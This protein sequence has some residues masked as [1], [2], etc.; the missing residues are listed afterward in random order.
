MRFGFFAQLKVRKIQ[1]IHGMKLV[2]GLTHV[3]LGSFSGCGGSG[4]IG[5]NGFLPQSQADKNVRGHV[6]RVGRIRRDFGIAPRRFQSL[7][8]KLGCIRRVNQ[9]VD[10][11]GMLRLSGH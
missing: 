11:A 1:K 10:C 7:G 6:K 4:E 2:L 8:R 5:I 9:V 3:V